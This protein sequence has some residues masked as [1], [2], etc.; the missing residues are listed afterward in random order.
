MKRV[1]ELFAEQPSVYDEF[2]A[3]ML[4]LEN[5]KVDIHTVASKVVML[6]RGH[7]DLIMSFNEYLPQGC[8]IEL[9]GMD[10]N[11]GERSG[12]AAAAAAASG[13]LLAE[14]SFEEERWEHYKRAQSSATNA[15]VN[16]SA[17]EASQQGEPSSVV[18]AGD[19]EPRQVRAAAA[20][21]GADARAARRR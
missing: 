9:T 12:A 4:D 5:D 19:G 10:L 7:D 20:R 1:K 16:A 13:D 11:D 21:G 2:V 17:S 15:A 6:F 18:G 3:V 14:K 8:R